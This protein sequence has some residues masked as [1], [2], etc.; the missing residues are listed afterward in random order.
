MTIR[1]SPLDSSA[2][3]VPRV[4][5]QTTVL[6]P[7]CGQPNPATAKQCAACGITFA[8]GRGTEK[9]DAILEDLLDLANAP[10]D[11]ARATSPEAESPDVDE[12]SAEQLVES[13]ADLPLRRRRRRRHGR[14]TR[15]LP[16]CEQRGGAGRPTGQRGPLRGRPPAL[17][18]RDP[19]GPPALVCV[20]VARRRDEVPRPA[21]RGL[22]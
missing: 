19:D 10:P 9:V 8:T 11:A 16:P 22:A 6:C 3:L 5:D 17:R 20:D 15:P 21:R 12:T 18:A 13:A 4:A 14:G 1:L 2:R 7:I